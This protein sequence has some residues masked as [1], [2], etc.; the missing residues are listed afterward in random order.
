M[1]FYPSIFDWIEEKKQIEKIKK[2]EKK[3]VKLVIENEIVTKTKIKNPLNK[4]SHLIL[5]VQNQK[6]LNNLFKLISL[7]HKGDNFY[8][9]PRIDYDLLEKYNE[10][11]IASSACLGGI[12]GSNLWENKENGLEC[13][14]SAMRNTTKKMIQIFGDRWYGELQWNSINEQHVLNQA[15]IQL[16]KEFGFKIIST[17]DSHYPKPENWIDRILYRKIGWLNK[18]YQDD[19]LPKSIDE[20]PYELYPKNGDQMWESYK[21]YSKSC[22]IEYEDQIILK[23]IEESHSIAFDKIEN[24]EPDCSIKL[25]NFLIPKNSSADEELENFCFSFL[26][27]KNLDTKIKYIEQL[28]KELEIIK[29]NKFSQYFLTMKAVSD[30]ARQITL[31]GAARGSAG[32]S[33]ISYLLGITQ[34]DPLRWN[35][36]FERFMRKDQKDYPDIDFDVRKFRIF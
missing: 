36:Q 14:L 21:K 3:S 8:R 30:K 16:S 35:L 17:V 9:F 5:L 29:N 2:K 4:R 18:K 26:K 6:G 12:Y 34:V 22:N 7:S 13:V 25:P 15:I 11:L 10:G 24:F 20:L 23:S 31:C 1:Y 27:K 19:V 32:G 33:L 28:K